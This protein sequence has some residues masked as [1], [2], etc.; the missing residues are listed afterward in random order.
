LINYLIFIQKLISYGH[1]IGDQPDSE[2]P[3]QLLIDRKWSFIKLG[4]IH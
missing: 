2:N 4:L 3:E 1:L